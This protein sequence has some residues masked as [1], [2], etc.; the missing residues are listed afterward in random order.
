[1]ANF[2]SG[3]ST[4]R[5]VSS[6]PLRCH[7]NCTVR[8]FRLSFAVLAAAISSAKRLISSRNWLA[9]ATARPFTATS[10]SPAFKPILAAGPP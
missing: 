7:T 5:F 8:T 4:T 10:L 6:W 2:K 9:E 1:M 3:V